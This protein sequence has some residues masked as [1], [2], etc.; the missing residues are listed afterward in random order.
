MSNTHT[1]FHMLGHHVKGMSYFYVNPLDVRKV[2]DMKVSTR[3]FC[4]F[5]RQYP[6][7]LKIKYSNPRET[8]G[9]NPVI[10]GGGVVL[11]GE[12]SESDVMTV[13]YQ[14]EEEAFNDLN[15][16][17]AKKQFLANEDSLIQHEM[18]KMYYRHKTLGGMEGLG[19]KE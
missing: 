1:L 17:H 19:S 2:L 11:S 5:D 7:T 3:L 9:I 18:L 6:Y 15:E 13:R 14:S 16:I 12:Y 10:G 4:L 8:V